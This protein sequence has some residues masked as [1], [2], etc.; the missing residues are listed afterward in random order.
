MNPKALRQQ[1]EELKAHPIAFFVRNGHMTII[2]LIGCILGG[3]YAFSSMPIESEPEVKIPIGVVSVPYPGASPGDTEKLITDELEAKLKNLDDLKRLTS[4]SLEGLANITVEFRAD[5]DLRESLRQLRDEVDSVRSELPEEAED[6]IVTEIRAGDRAILTFTLLGQQPLSEL[7]RYAKLFED[8]L[9]AIAG[10]NKVE[11]YGLPE[12]EMQVLIDKAALEGFGLSLQEVASVI[13]RNH[14]DIPIGRIRTDDYYYQA[15]F[16]GEFGSPEQLENLAIATKGVTPIYLKD[17]AQ[18]RYAFGETT[19]ET[20]LFTAQ[21]QEGSNAGQYRKAV[22]LGV[23]K[24]VGAD[25]VDMADTAKLLAEEF[26]TQLPSGMVLVVTDDESDRIRQDISRL[27][28]S[29]WQTIAIIALTLLLAL[30]VKEALAAAS[31][32]PILYL[33]TIMGLALSGQ[34]FNFLT[35]FALILSLGVVIDTSIVIIEGVYEYRKQGLSTEDAALAAVSTFKAPLIAGTLTTIAAFLPLGLMTG[36]MGE[37]VKHIPTTVNLTLVASLITALM[38]LPAITIWLFKRPSKRTYTPPLQKYFGIVGTW[39]QKRIGKILRS[40]D[41][42][43]R[44]LTGVCAAFFFSGV[45][46]T[47]G[48]VKFNLFS[49]VD[50]NLFFVNIAAPE[51]TSLERTRQITQQVETLLEDTPHLVRFVTTYGGGGFADGVGSAPQ[52]GSHKASISVTLTDPDE[53]RIKSFEITK[54]LRKKLSS[55]TE[56]EVLIQELSAGPPSGADIQV[57]LLGQD[58]R[59][60]QTYAATVQS[61][62]TTIDGA[63]DI[64]NDLELA[65]GKYTLTPKRDRLSTFGLTASDV[66]LSL[67]TAVFG[68]E[69]QEIR[70][71]G[72][73]EDIVIRIDYRNRDCTDSPLTALE[74]AK[75]NVTICRSNPEDIQELLGLLLQTPNGQVPV[76]ELVDVELTSAITTIRHFN[77]RRV[78]SVKAHV[79]EGY[80]VADVLTTLQKRLDAAGIPDSVSIEYGGEN[81][82][83]LESMASL[84]VASLLALMLIFVILVYQFKSFGQVFIVLSTM[85]LAIMGVLYG[86]AL[87]RVPLSFP[88]MIGAVALL[89]IVVNDAIVLIDKMNTNVKHDTNTLRAVQQACIARLEPVIMTTLTTAL[90]VLPLI[91]SGET[92]RDLAIV[93]AIGIVIATIFTLVIVPVLYMSLLEGAFAPRSVWKSVRYF[94]GTYMPQ[95]VKSVVKTYNKK[96]VQK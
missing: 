18:V 70:R 6:P 10:V 88:G 75:D 45:M 78:V 34:T 12:R 68:D 42:R 37:Y 74:E 24:T 56:A 35:F 77:T 21:S 54:D 55:I 46:F 81:E 59:S 13:Q 76:S 41:A 66:G 96:S 51:G 62:L 63:T 3:L 32:L 91:F 15:S 40:A 29:A 73:E 82:D 16:A 7:K 83:T 69:S 4:D 79:Q 26:N 67:R 43:R 33:I 8:E 92:F 60:V 50:F 30:G 28:R 52:G 94:A 17:I 89:G 58:I 5:A 48:I 47:T 71:E 25:L 44:W 23:F 38:I 39:Y 80:T 65:P 85:P 95:R 11:I 20:R 61:L 87:I 53:R 93:L 2:T 57:R 22:T 27:V 86:L 19:T 49:S 64:T 14:I 9:E 36:I 84:R 31:S 1:A 72:E 90:G